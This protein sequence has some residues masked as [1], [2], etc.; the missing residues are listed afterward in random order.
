MPSQPADTTV[1][2]RTR[3]SNAIAHPEK[4]EQAAAQAAAVEA[5]AKCIAGI[6]LEMEAKQ[7]STLAR[8]AKGV[9]P[10]SIPAKGKK[11]V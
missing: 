1:T 6:E 2:H 7:T 9:R 5:G 8:K 10:R 11:A 4:A 3:P